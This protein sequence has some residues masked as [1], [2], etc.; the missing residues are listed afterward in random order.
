MG[1]QKRKSFSNRSRN[2]VQLRSFCLEMFH[3]LGDSLGIRIPDHQL[4]R[5]KIDTPNNY[6]EMSKVHRSFKYQFS[7]FVFDGPRMFLSRS[8][9]FLKYFVFFLVF[10]CLL[11]LSFVHEVIQDIHWH[12]EDDCRVVFSCNTAKGLKIAQL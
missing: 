3:S 12:W 9:F 2:E 4:K 7:L 8:L 6:S 10:S 5:D 11:V 1:L